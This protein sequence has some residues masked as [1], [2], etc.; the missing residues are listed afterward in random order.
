MASFFSIFIYSL[1]HIPEGKCL[2]D[3]PQSCGCGMPG[4]L[5]LWIGELFLSLV[6]SF[7]SL[8]QTL[9]RPEWLRRQSPS[10]SRVVL[11][12]C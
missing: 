12:Q 1:H 6:E 5:H 4:V 3:Y 10:N 8:V 2:Y 11:K 7:H 9:L